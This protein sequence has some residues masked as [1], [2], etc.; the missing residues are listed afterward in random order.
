MMYLHI[1]S[2][3]LRKIKP[4]SVLGE[5]EEESAVYTVKEQRDFKSFFSPN[6]RDNLDFHQN[7]TFNAAG[8][9]ASSLI[10]GIFITLQHAMIINC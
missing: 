5:S 6:N 9:L 8:W 3:P 1:L 10:E 2:L 4:S 7:R